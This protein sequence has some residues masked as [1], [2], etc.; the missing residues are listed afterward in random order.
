M[1][2]VLVIKVRNDSLIFLQPLPKP[3]SLFTTNYAGSAPSGGADGAVT[4]ASRFSNAS[5]ATATE[6]PEASAGPLPPLQEAS[7]AK[8]PQ[9]KRCA[10][11]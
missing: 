4:T 3:T 7:S 2:S 9:A 8:R 10:R 11:G 6:S 1:G 5:R